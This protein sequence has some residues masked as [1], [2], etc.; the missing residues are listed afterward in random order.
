MIVGRNTNPLVVV[1]AKWIEKSTR[2]GDFFVK[3]R[4]VDDTSLLKEPG[5]TDL[6]QRVH[7]ALEEAEAALVVLSPDDGVG[8]ALSGKKFLPRPNVSYELGYLFARLPRSHVEIL[9]DCT[10]GK[11]RDKD[12]TQVEKQSWIPD[13][14]S[15][16]LSMYK[17]RCTSFQKAK[18]IVTQLL[19]NLG[20]T[21]SSHQDWGYSFKFSDL[22]RFRTRE[23]YFIWLKRQLKASEPDLAWRLLIEHAQF[24]F[25][26]LGPQ[27][28]LELRHIVKEPSQGKQAKLMIEVMS[29]YWRA[30][31]QRNQRQAILAEAGKLLDE[32]TDE[33]EWGKTLT[34]PLLRVLYCDYKGLLSEA[35]EQGETKALVWF[36]QA[37]DQAQL[38]NDDL[39]D[40]WLGYIW[41]NVARVVSNEETMDK[42]DAYKKALI[43]RKISCQAALGTV[44]ETGRSYQLATA[45]G[46]YLTLLDKNVTINFEEESI[47]PY[48]DFVEPVMSD[49]TTPQNAFTRGRFTLF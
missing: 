43:A 24:L 9:V 33:K 41:F 40:L 21:A 14:P 15:D 17:K 20:A 35:Q 3:L 12:W 39:R 10:Y 2:S 23:D 42:E 31:V 25:D 36:R 46:N 13:Q 49:S 29:T 7:D 19:G 37:I 4:I 8:T 22:T 34:V 38:L 11:N 47:K 5:T 48:R 30:S 45:L 18:R 16:L 6:I 44:L 1:L 27:A 32:L 28:L 26:D